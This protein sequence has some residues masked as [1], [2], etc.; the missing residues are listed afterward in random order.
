MK[1]AFAQCGISV[2]YTMRLFYSTPI[3]K[4]HV[5]L[6]FP[7]LARRGQTSQNHIFVGS[8]ENVLRYYYQSELVFIYS[9]F[10]AKS[11]PSPPFTAM[12]VK[13]TT[14]SPLNFHYTSPKPVI[15]NRCGRHRNTL[16]KVTC[17]L[18]GVPSKLPSAHSTSSRIRAKVYSLC[19]VFSSVQAI[20]I[21][22][23]NPEV[24]LSLFAR[25]GHRIRR[26]A[27]PVLVQGLCVNLGRIN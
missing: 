16:E 9:T 26:L 11:Y 8:V 5:D 25:E 17:R 1:Y 2:M 23:T 15:S 10:A 3:E 22:I 7:V 19:A 24:F 12:K 27:F 20:G 18:H 21:S 6:R 13:P 14:R 4:K